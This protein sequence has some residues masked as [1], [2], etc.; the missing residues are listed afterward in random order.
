M[1]NYFEPV[2]FPELEEPVKEVTRSPE[3]ED[4][5]GN[6]PMALQESRRLFEALRSGESNIRKVALMLDAKEPSMQCF[7]RLEATPT[8]QNLNKFLLLAKQDMGRAAA[9]ELQKIFVAMDPNLEGSI[10]L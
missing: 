9:L 8:K 7:Q 4:L 2:E 6:L 10:N 1:K 5:K 3:D